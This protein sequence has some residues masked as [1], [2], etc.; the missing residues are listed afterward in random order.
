MNEKLLKMIGEVMKES[1]DAIKSEFSNQLKQA[2]DKFE[3]EIESL[4]K[5]H[6]IQLEDMQE[7][8]KTQGTMFQEKLEAIQ[9]KEGIPGQD[10][11]S[12]ELED[13]ITTLT[14]DDQFM[15]Q[16]KGEKGEPGEKGL[17]GASVELDEVI[18]TFKADDEFM[19]M[20]KGE[21][22]EQGEAVILED[23]IDYLKGD[24]EFLESVKGIPGE[25]VKAEEVALILAEDELFRESIKGEKGEPGKD[26][27]FTKAGSY[28]GE[29]TKKYDFIVYKGALWQNLMEDNDSEPSLENKS[30]QC[31]V[32]KPKD[33]KS[34]VPKGLYKEDENY[35]EN[36][37]VMFNNASWIKNDKA[38]QELPGEG[39][40]LLA[41]GTKGSKGDT[42]E[43]GEPG[44]VI[45]ITKNLEE[46]LHLLEAKGIVNEN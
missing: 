16:V 29:P 2:S 25:S 4:T 38:S 6:A 40:F 23:V 7:L 32:E 34:I 3:N 26:G 11:K 12:V 8:M 37:V 13:V 43:K 30:Y 9:L 36:N 5:A 27:V 18:K 42:G 10:G 14:S 31:I 41:K 21:Q 1:L 15:K 35:E 19:V 44:V 28:T 17:D 39:W 33:G 22:G 20:I 45:D 24:T 46:R